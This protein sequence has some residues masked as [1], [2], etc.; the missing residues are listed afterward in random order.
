ML[1]LIF[2]DVNMLEFRYLFLHLLEIRHGR[3]NMVEGSLIEM[4]QMHIRKFDTGLRASILNLVML[5]VVIMFRFL[6]SQHITLLNI[7]S[8]CVH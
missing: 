7:Q 4:T 2:W 3:G 5:N 8:D 6:S 1:K